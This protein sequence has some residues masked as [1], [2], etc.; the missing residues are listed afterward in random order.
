MINKSA[1]SAV[2][3]GFS[4]ATVSFLISSCKTDHGEEIQKKISSEPPVSE[5][6]AQSEKKEETKVRVK[7][8][9]CKSIGTELVF[10]PPSS[11]IMGNNNSF[12]DEKPEHLIRISR[13]FW[14]AKTEVTQGQYK[15][16]MKKSPSFNPSGADYPVEQVS[17]NDAM[18][19]CKVLTEMEKELIPDGYVFRLPTEAEWE[20]F[21]KAGKI[22]MDRVDDYAW[23]SGNSGNDSHASAQKKPDING[24]YDTIGNV[25]EWCL[26]SC[27]MDENGVVTDTYKGSVSDPMSTKGEYKIHRGGSWCYDKAQC[28]PT[29]RYADE[30][31][32]TSGDLGFR[33]VLAPKM[34]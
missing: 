9:K 32:F 21:C 26:D 11:F 14:V 2:T 1:L 29:R 23:H 30:A 28:T 4:I 24:L 22:N 33:V 18:E 27:D 13:E 6:T 7:K 12:P 5:F 25:W 8:L 16:I 15:K 31:D 20:Y 17:W 19:F 10:F 34:K 3:L